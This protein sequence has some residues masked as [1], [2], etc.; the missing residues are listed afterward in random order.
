M[1]GLTP[2]DAAEWLRQAPPDLPSEDLIPFDLVG[3]RPR[4]LV[5]WPAG[6][7][8]APMWNLIPRRADVPYLC[9]WHGITVTGG[10]PEC[11]REH[12][13]YRESGTWQ[14]RRP[15]PS[16]EEL[17]AADRLAALTEELGLYEAGPDCG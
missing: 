14:D 9:D 13:E 2:E 4:Y 8:H 11:V 1:P 5:E 3:D 7:P 16:P 6:L 15:V 17:A 12:A 10:C